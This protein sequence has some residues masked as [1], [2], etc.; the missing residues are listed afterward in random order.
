MRLFIAL[1]LPAEIRDAL[2]AWSATELADRPELRVV[3]PEA[4]HVTLA[5]LGWRAVR[6]A[7][8][9]GEILAE[10]AAPV[11]GL[12]V[13]GTAWLP[14]RRPR[15]LAVD[16]EDPAGEMASLQARVLAALVAQVGFEPESRPFRPH[17][18]VARVKKRA[19]GP[20]SRPPGPRCQEF[21]GAAVTLYRSRPTRDGARY[22]R[23][24]HVPM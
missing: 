20:L 24:C 15:V 10:A 13:A 5:F 3:P 16:V 22:D 19:D 1:D 18:T 23:V 14:R 11:R 17:V 6:D 4:L 9:L 21:G 7:P 12:S 8:L 2:A